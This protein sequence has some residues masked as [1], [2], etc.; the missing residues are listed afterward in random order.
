MVKL[1]SSADWAIVARPADLHFLFLDWF[2]GRAYARYARQKEVNSAIEVNWCVVGFNDEISLISGD[3]SSEKSPWVTFLV[4]V[5]VILVSGGY[6][7]Q[8]QGMHVRLA[9]EKKKGKEP[10][11]VIFVEWVFIGKNV[12]SILR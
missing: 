5:H 8:G 4:R 2:W 12:K 9:T 11:T 10:S 1:F 6:D 7:L 3:G